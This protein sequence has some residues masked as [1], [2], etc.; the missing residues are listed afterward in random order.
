MS[1]LVSLIKWP[2]AIA[3]AVLTPA[4][5][6]AFWA[7]LRAAW[8]AEL[9]ASPFAIGFGGMLLFMLVFRRTRFVQ[10][11]ST[12]EHELTHALFAWLTLVPVHELRTTDGSRAARGDSSLGH[13]SL[14]GS[15]WLIVTA[16]YFFPTASAALLVAIWIL[17]AS[18]TMAA[19]ALLGV[20]TAWCV[21]S[22]WHET[23]KGQSDLQKAGLG[24]SLLFL[25]GANILCYGM[26]LANE[27]AG[28]SGAWAFACSAPEITME[29]MR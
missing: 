2:I 27:L 17:A 4:A 3:V 26:L 8:V 15:N 29:W 14:G 11:W 9:W 21:V 25:P 10:F 6:V 13:V 22:T 18:P 16:P 12:L 20:A 1:A 19:R 28:P 23:H 24:F 5:A 7:L